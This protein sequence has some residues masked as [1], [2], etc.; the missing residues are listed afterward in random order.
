MPERA[1][2]APIFGIKRRASFRSARI[3][4]AT[5]SFCAD[6]RP[7]QAFSIA[8]KSAKSLRICVTLY[9]NTVGESMR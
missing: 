4:H 5:E 1:Q 3:A 6:G 8:V 2:L 9:G 7:A